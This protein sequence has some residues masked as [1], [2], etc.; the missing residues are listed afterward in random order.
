[1]DK[2]TAAITGIEAYRPDYILRNQELEKII[3]TT[4]EWI[5][6][7]TG[8][9]ERRILKG[10]G[11]GT[12]FIGA[13]AIKGL[14][15]KTNTKPEE[16]DLVICSTITADMQFPAT[17]NII[18]DMVGIKNAWSFDINAACSGFIYAL[19]TASKFVETGYKKVIV[20]SGDKMSSIIDYTDRQTCII[21][22]DGGGAVL[23]EPNTEG[24]GVIDTMLH[25]DGSGRKHLHQ[26]AGGSVKPASHETID[27]REHFVYQ[28]GQAV[29][30]FAVSRM[31][32]ISVEMMNKHN[33]KS[34]DLAWLV[35]HQANLRIIEA[36][37]RRM[38]ISKEQVMINIQ[39]YGN[40]TNGTIPLLLSDWEK[41]L[42]KGD[43]LI[44][45]SFG[46]GFTWGSVYL[47]WAY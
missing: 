27:A 8:I 3:D 25:V 19:T 43:K 16:I 26:K 10:E 35:P 47:K 40:T 15:K 6:T 20:I 22:G 37:A 41:E 7:R 17:A 2:I 9:S 46:A 13:E 23:L 5:L 21:F 24:Y 31:A 14:L 1:M 39:K 28:E 4:D 12:S 36:T 18:S 34:E 29:F 45:S 42:K 30:K 44:I 38:G 11:L 33:I 32:D